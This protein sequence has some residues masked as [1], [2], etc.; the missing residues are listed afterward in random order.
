[1]KW[2]QLIDETVQI[3]KGEFEALIQTAEVVN[4]ETQAVIE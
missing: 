2:D 1:M 3:I 4:D